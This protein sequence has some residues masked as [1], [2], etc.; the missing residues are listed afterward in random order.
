[1]TIVVETIAVAPAELQVGILMSSFSCGFKQVDC[2]RE[3]LLSSRASV[4]ALRKTE[5]YFCLGRYSC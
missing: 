2:F 4:V 5:G 1:M 3:I